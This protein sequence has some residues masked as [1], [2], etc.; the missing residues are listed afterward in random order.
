MSLWHPVSL[1]LTVKTKTSRLALLITRSIEPVASSSR[2]SLR[3]PSTQSSVFPSEA[4]VLRGKQ[5]ERWWWTKQC[6]ASLT[7]CAAQQ[8]VCAVFQD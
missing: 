4:S 3:G 2:R 7:H 6:Q 5:C 8:I 1:Q